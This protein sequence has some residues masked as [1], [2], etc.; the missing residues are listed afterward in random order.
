[1]DSTTFQNQL[2]TCYKAFRKAPKTMKMVEAETGIDRPNI[3]RYVAFLEKRQKITVVK[4]D[5]CTIT[6]H[7]AKYYS[8]NPQ[9]F[10]PITQ[11]ELFKSERCL[12]W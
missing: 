6:K 7:H 5:T 3:C 11:T 8:T 12:V 10:K 2:K 9:Y 4:K 1:M